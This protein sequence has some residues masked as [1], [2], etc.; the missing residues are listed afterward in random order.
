M[1]LSH[2]KTA[3]IAVLVLFSTQYAN[4][5][6]FESFTP[7]TDGTYT[8]SSTNFLGQTWTTESAHT[9]TSLDIKFSGSGNVDIHISTTT[10]AGLPGSDIVVIENITVSGVTNVPIPDCYAL[11]NAEKYAYWIEWNSGAPYLEAID[12]GGYTGGHFVVGSSVSPPNET[13]SRDGYFIIY[14]VA[15]DCG[16]EESPPTYSTTTIAS[17]TLQ[18]VGATTMGFGIIITIAF[19]YLIAYLYNSMFRKKPWQVS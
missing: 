12:A 11:N 7:T 13:R 16:A 17:T 2:A 8:I 14:G 15:G 9:I 19:L 4:A 10:E 6:T 5:D 1:S 18:L 3:L